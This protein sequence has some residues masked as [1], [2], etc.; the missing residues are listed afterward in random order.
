[1]SNSNLF[2]N[3]QL[4]TTTSLTTLY[5]CPSSNTN[6]SVSASIV[7]LLQVANVT[8]RADVVTVLWT[9]ASTS[10]SIVRLAYQAS[11]PAQSSIGILTGKLPL[12]PGDTVKVQTGI[13]NSCEVTLGTLETQ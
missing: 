3:A 5:T 13:F 9:K 1:M 12:M 6:G 7:F 8:S 4:I 11:V 2:V 10:N